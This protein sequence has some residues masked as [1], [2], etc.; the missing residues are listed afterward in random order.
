MEYLANSLQNSFDIR[1]K[2]L[3]KEIAETLVPTVNRVKALYRVLDEKVDISFGKGVIIF[4]NACKEAEAMAIK[5]QD[6]LKHAYATT[7]VGFKSIPGFDLN[8][9]FEQ[10]KVE[11]LLIQLREAYT[12]RDRLWTELEKAIDAIGDLLPLP[13]SSSFNTPFQLNL[14][15]KVYEIHQERLNIPLLTSNDTQKNWKRTTLDQQ[16]QPR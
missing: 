9:L 8:G 15:W 3:K 14:P 1:G 6:D 5:E 4:N 13:P 11:G 2:E 16:L 10:G 7:K 12:R